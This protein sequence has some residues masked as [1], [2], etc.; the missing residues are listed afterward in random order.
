MAGCNSKVYVLRS[1]SANMAKY[2]TFRW[3]DTKEDENGKA[4]RP[5]AFAEISVRN[6]VREVLEQEGWK[7]VRQNPDVLLSYDILMERN[8]VHEKEVQATS[9]FTRSYYNPYLRRWNRIHY[10]AQFVGYDP[11]TNLT[12]EATLT[13][14]MMD[15]RTDEA[16]WQGWSTE[17]LSHTSL[18]E[19]AIEKTVNKILDKL[20]AQ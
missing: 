12:K 17:R 6:S 9:A 8:A 3:V 4:Q 1:E 10:P 18:S 20:E 11:G 15:A 19:E 2:R 13:L 14:T 16:L 5:S 7:E